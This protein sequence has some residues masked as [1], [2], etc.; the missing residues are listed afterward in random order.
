MASEIETSG[1]LTI[2][3]VVGVFSSL[4]SVLGPVI[5][6]DGVN[7]KLESVAQFPYK[8][9]RVIGVVNLALLAPFFLFLFAL[10]SFYRIEMNDWQFYSSGFLAY[11]FLSFQNLHIIA[12]NYLVERRELIIQLCLLVSQALLLT[13]LIV[14]F[15]VKSSTTLYLIQTSIV[16]FISV[17]PS[18]L[19]LR[20][21][22]HS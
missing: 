18:I 1:Y 4:S 8:S 16:L 7:R 3:L 12:S 15:D 2:M 14:I 11:L 21:K 5:W 13:M 20:S 19:I 10:S 9:Y 6:N 22:D 17:L